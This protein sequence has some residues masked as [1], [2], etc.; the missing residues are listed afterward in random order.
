MA[1]YRRKAFNTGKMFQKGNFQQYRKGDIYRDPRIQQKIGDKD[2]LVIDNDVDDIEFLRLYLNGKLENYP[3][4]QYNMF[5]TGVDAA[6]TPM[7]G[8]YWLDEEL[9]QYKRAIVLCRGGSEDVVLDVIDECCEEVPTPEVDGSVLNKY[10]R[11][12]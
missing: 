12:T 3:S 7:I 8:L 10:V 1:K 5:T 9:V 6:G 11:K 2:F 4:E